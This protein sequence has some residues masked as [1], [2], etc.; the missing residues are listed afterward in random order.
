MHTLCDQL[1]CF[2]WFLSKGAEFNDLESISLFN[3]TIVIIVGYVLSGLFSLIRCI[4]LL[5][6]LSLVCVVCTFSLFFVE[7]T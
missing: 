7:F 1:C 4:F 6:E 3:Y 5:F 2:T